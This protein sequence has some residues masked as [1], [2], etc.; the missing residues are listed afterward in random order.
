MTKKQ[1]IV[2]L[3]WI[4]ILSFAFLAVFWILSSI[5]GAKKITEG[6][7]LQRSI[8]QSAGTT[9]VAL[10]IRA[11][12]LEIDSKNKKI[13]FIIAAIAA[14]VAI[15]VAIFEFSAPDDNNL[16]VIAALVTLGVGIAASVAVFLFLKNKPNS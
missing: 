9:T 7:T 2:L 10:L 13:C 8:S 3:N 5:E 12:W 1:G 14:V 15:V 11:I 16:S 4:I 6:Y